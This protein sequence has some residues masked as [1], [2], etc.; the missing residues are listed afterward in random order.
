[1]IPETI[2]NVVTF[3]G[4]LIMLLTINVKLAIITCAPI[5]LILISGIIFSKKVRPFFGVSTKK[6]GEFNAKLQ[7]NLSGMHEIQS[8]GREGYEKGRVN[9]KNF[10]HVHAMLQALKV[11]AVFHPSVSGIHIFNRD[12]TRCGCG[13]IPC[14]QR[15]AQG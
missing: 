6:M 9:D 5:P 13:R 2:T 15:Q 8:F 12:H 4:V 14:I 7:D 11:S 3:L 1:M 10:G